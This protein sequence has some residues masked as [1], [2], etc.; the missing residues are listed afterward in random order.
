MRGKSLII[1]NRKK[2]HPRLKMKL[3]L[4]DSFEQYVRNLHPDQEEDYIAECR[5]GSPQAHLYPVDQ[6]KLDRFIK[7]MIKD[8][9]RRALKNT[10]SHYCREFSHPNFEWEVRK[11]IEAGK[12]KGRR[13]NNAIDIMKKEIQDKYTGRSQHFFPPY[14]EP[15][16][17]LLLQGL[18]ERVEL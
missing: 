1:V 7:L 10:L 6:I 14:D 11:A 12:R 8:W 3:L 9:R 15:K 16:P 5:E 18:E 17:S 2:D 13:F 4:I